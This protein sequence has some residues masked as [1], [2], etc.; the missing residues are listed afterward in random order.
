MAI[1]V[2]VFAVDRL[3]Q[4]SPDETEIAYEEQKTEQLIVAIFRK[5]KVIGHLVTNVRYELPSEVISGPPIPVAMIIGD[6]LHEVAYGMKT[7]ELVH[8]KEDNLHKIEAKLTK[9][10]NERRSPLPVRNLRL[11]NTRLMMK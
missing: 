11:E 8:L 1:S 3:P 5:G 9:V 4:S 2:A 10:L 6:G 7:K